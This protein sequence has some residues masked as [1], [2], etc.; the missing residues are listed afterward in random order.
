M[1]TDPDAPR[2]TMI[3]P[4]RE[5][6]IRVDSVAEEY[7]FIDTYPPEDG[8]WTVVSQ[9]LVAAGSGPVDWVL[10]RAV[11]TDLEFVVKFD[12]A[13]FVDTSPPG[14]D[15]SETSDRLDVIMKRALD[16]ARENPPFHPG[17]M[18]RFPVPS[19][20]YG[21][22]VEVPIAILAVDAGR[23]GLYAPTRVVALDLSTGEPVGIG[24]APDFDP[25]NWPP[26]RLGDW[27]PAGDR[28]LGRRQLQA[29]LNRFSACYLRLLD[30]T[31]LGR[32]YE[33]RS[34]EEREAGVLLTHLEP[35][36]MIEW[37][38]NLDA[39][40]MDRLGDQASTT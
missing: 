39:E 14:R 28:P 37:Y 29:T 33:Q 12:V 32:E 20:R 16:Y 6:L 31:V 7:A 40:W 36:S 23:R 5:P 38:R 26:R 24:E 3:P 10:L 9:S 2:P 17:S 1:T 21:N 18:P 30:A 11:E 22:C 25:Q 19:R 35:L 8:W 13:S 27:P 34:D 15:A 4:R